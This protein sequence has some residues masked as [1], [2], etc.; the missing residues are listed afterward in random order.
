MQQVF[1]E[2]H[3]LFTEVFPESLIN[4]LRLIPKNEAFFNIHFPKNSELLSRAEFRLKFEELFFIQLQLLSKNLVR[5]HKIKGFAFENVGNYF[6]SFYH[7]HLPFPLTNAQKRVIKEIRTDM[8]HE[9]QMNRLL[10]GDVGAGKT[11][12]GF[13]SMLLALDNGFQ[14]CL[15]A[16]TEILANQ[17][18]IGIKEMA[19]KIGVEVALLTGSTK[20]KERNLIHENLENGTIQILIGTHALLEDKVK[21]HN[22][23]L[24]IIDEQH[25]FGVE[26]R[27][28]K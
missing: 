13:M 12:V 1:M 17:H 9:A 22:L 27:S 10:Q 14:A 25:R 19:D 4:E 23:G 3:H 7:E 2:T 6:N 21:Y 11:I 5:K 28:K 15:M 8:A 24:S 18:F 20:T 26:Q 16:P